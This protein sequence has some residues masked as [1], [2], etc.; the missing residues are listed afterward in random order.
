[1]NPLTIA[2]QGLLSTPLQIAA[3]G[4]LPE[5]TEQIEIRFGGQAGPAQKKTRKDTDDDVLIFI[6]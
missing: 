2:L 5:A 6:L 3:Q 1:M 4:L